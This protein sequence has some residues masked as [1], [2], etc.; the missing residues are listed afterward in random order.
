M[1]RSSFLNCSSLIAT[2]FSLR[3][4]VVKESAV[5]ENKAVI[6]IQSSTI[7][8]APRLTTTTTGIKLER[9]LVI[10]VFFWHACV[11]TY[12]MYIGYT[13]LDEK[14]PESMNKFIH[15]LVFV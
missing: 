12:L 3:G 6:V 10:H 5:E 2:R 8:D 11:N 15:M 7:M 9:K 1:A 4:V 13:Q 14:Q